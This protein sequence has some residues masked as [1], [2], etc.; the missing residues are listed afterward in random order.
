MQIFSVFFLLLVSSAAFAIDVSKLADLIRQRSCEQSLV[1]QEVVVV[2]GLGNFEYVG[3]RHNLGTEVVAAIGDTWG[4]FDYRLPDHINTYMAKDEEDAARYVRFSAASYPKKDG[5]KIDYRIAAKYSVTKGNPTTS[6]IIFLHPYYDINESGHVV[7]AVAK[8]AG[9][10]PEQLIVFVD[11]LTLRRGEIKIATG[12]PDGSGDQ[13]NGLKS[14]NEHLGT[15]AYVRVRL[16]VSSEKAE[17]VNVL[18]T[19]WV[20]G[21]VPPE[22]RQ[23]FFAPSKIED[24]GLLI[25]NLQQRVGLEPKA[26]QKVVQEGSTI[27]QRLNKKD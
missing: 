24:F 11:D 13:H 9:L 18:R 23:Q 20:L 26:K 15:G 19:Q 3:T 1:G 8:E 17:G 7:S 27:I 4:A 10:R 16:G 12:K 21:E 14:L 2:V 22:D 25:S 6:K 5:L